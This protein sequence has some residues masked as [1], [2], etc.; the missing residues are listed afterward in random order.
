MNTPGR[1]AQANYLQ[2]GDEAT[3]DAV[4]N[5][6]SS[7]KPRE[8]ARELLEAAGGTPEARQNARAALW[9]AVKTK[10]MPAQG[11]T[12]NDRWDAKK[13][14]AFFDDPK[15]A[16]VAEELW[17]DAP[18]DLAS[19]K[20]FFGALAGA[21]GSVRTRAPNSSGTA[22]ALSGKFDQSLSAASVASRA[23]S[24]NRGVLSPGIAIVDVA[25]TW[26]RN[27]SKQVQS[28]AID[29]LASAAFNNPNLAAD[30]LEKYNPADFAAKR[31]LISQKYGARATQVLNLLDEM[32][33][34]DEFTDAVK[35]DDS[36]GK[37]PL[38]ITVGRSR[39]DELID[40][41]M[42]GR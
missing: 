15:T 11:A 3:V 40:A 23:R 22:Q 24:V 1:S 2:Y 10:R 9:E 14:K 42:R 17:S 5:L 27:R 20:E 32:Q 39:D 31:R 12:G 33:D 16:A 18:D 28:R 29:T 38:E 37:R 36:G 21:E 34:E 30:L 8:A 25:A 4:R 6:V 7:P 26:L 19:I 41:V 35:G 13:L